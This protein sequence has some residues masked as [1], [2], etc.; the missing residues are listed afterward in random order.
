VILLSSAHI[1][2]DTLA[3]GLEQGADCYITKPIPDRELQARVKTALKLKLAE[4]RLRQSEEQFR[5]MFEKHNAIMLLIEPVTGRIINANEAA[6]RF[7]G[8]TLSQLRSMSIQDINILPPDEVE[9]EFNLAIQERRNYFVFPHRLANGEVRTVEVHS[10]PVEQNDE[11]FLFSIIHDITDRKRAEE[12][13]KIASAYNRTLFETSPDALVTI[14]AEGKLTDVNTATERFTGFSRD[15]LIGTDFSDYFTDPE[16]ARAGYQQVFRDGSVKDYEL[17]LRDKNGP[18]AVVLYNASVYR[19]ESGKVMGIFAAARDVTGLKEAERQLREFN[20]TLEKRVAERSAELMAAN[21]QLLREIEEHAVT[22][23]SLRDSETRL[24]MVIESSPIGIFV[25][26][27]GKYSFANQAL[28][29][30]FGLADKSDIVRKAPET[31]FGDVSGRQFS[32]ILKQ[33]LG[34]SETLNVNEFKVLTRDQRER[35]LNI[36]LQPIELSGFSV[37][38]GFVIDVSDEIELRKHLNQAQKMEAL[39]SLAGGIAHDFNNVLFGITGYTELAL[40]ETS[41]EPRLKKQLEHILGA[42]RRASELVKQILTF[43]RGREQEKQP[44]I[45]SPIVKESLN[46]LRASITQNIEIRR[47]VRANLQCVNADPTQIHQIIMNLATNAYHS[48]KDT[49]GVLDVSLEQ[50]ELTPDFVRTRPGIV[51]G[52]YQKLRVSDTG[53]GMNPET[54]ERIFDPYFTTKEPGQGTGLGLSVVDSIVRDHGGAITVDSIAGV[55]TTFEVYFPIINAK[56]MSCEEPEQFAPLGKGQI[57]FVDDETMVTDATRFN[58][59]SLGY[60]VQ[61]ENDPVRA[62][63]KFEVQP[64]AFDLVITDMSMPKMTGLE[65]SGR[66]NRIRKDIPIVLI[67]GLAD[68]VEDI[69]LSEYGIRELVMK[70]VKKAVFGQTLSN[71]L[72]KQDG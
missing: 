45:M 19:D 34:R 63:A 66:I 67:T 40:S 53:H 29:T 3:E 4:R 1:E 38:M 71:I 52:T 70:P 12:S 33:C 43:S 30:I 36:W 9:R 5:G 15:E 6:E 56:K 13:L 10:S 54:L 62:L 7:Y 49:G 61:T 60:N 23:T 20:E 25:I 50:V 59:E 2:S 69:N 44:L 39:R 55:G 27:E 18:A 65:L 17:E 32:V 22:T 35:H 16:K 14:S 68:L 57:L 26:K 72:I 64:Y 48:M 28:M 58:L 37:V 42:A 11:K 21:R 51:P 31:P 47:D 46:F 8:Y 24:R 41:I